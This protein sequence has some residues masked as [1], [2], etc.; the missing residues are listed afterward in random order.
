ME[1]HTSENS[2]NSKDLSRMPLLRSLNISRISGVRPSQ[3]CSKH[4]LFILF[5]IFTAILPF[6]LFLSTESFAENYTDKKLLNVS[7]KGFLCLLCP[8]AGYLADV[9]F[10]RF[11]TIKFSTYIIATMSLA[12][13]LLFPLLVFI[14]QYHLKYYNNMLLYTLYV[15]IIIYGFGYI[16]FVSNYLQFSTDQLRDAPTRESSLFFYALFW[17]I[18]CTKLIGSVINIPLFNDIVIDHGNT[19]FGEPKT[20][21]VGA[22]F[23]SCLA[24]S[25]VVIVILRKYQSWFQDE[26]M[27]K[28]PYKTVYKILKFAWHHK[29]PLRPPTA[30]VYC[31]DRRRSRLDN[32]KERYGGL[33]K[34]EEVEDVKV[35][36][37]IIRVLVTIGPA[38]LMEMIG[39]I[40]VIHHKYDQN[41]ILTIGDKIKFIMLDYGMLSFLIPAGIIPA[42][43]F[44]IKS[45]FERY[46]PNMF[47]RMGLGFL[48]LIA[49]F[50][51]CLLY[52]LLAYDVQDIFGLYY[53][54][55]MYQTNESFV[56]SHSFFRI[57]SAYMFSA[58]H[59]LS[60][61]ATI[62]LYTSVWEF[63][64]CQSPHY[65]K[66]LLFGSLYAIQGFYKSLGVLILY[67]FTFSWES[68]LLS[69]RSTFYIVNLVIG[70]LFFI[71]YSVVTRKYKY[72]QRND[73]CNYY[74]FAE[75]YYSNIQD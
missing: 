54:A 61:I 48:L 24:C 45:C 41:K 50:G 31:E 69:C 18:N 26:R 38:F 34:T 40:L 67:G 30:F 43:I 68:T 35:L 20:Y 59:V 42:Y 72:R 8:I 58:L 75:N 3:L 17:T 2:A 33:Y 32:A 1:S 4:L 21:I 53:Y 14:S 6:I 60:S 7:Y 55:C 70:V 29:T 37:G 51:L 15:T 64:C 73:I 56:I 25:V 63:I 11:K 10:G 23:C 74:Q 62:L 22:A 49:L 65:M 46:V 5:W 71:A 13:A 12:F 47:R 66:G 36:F 9:K 57:P 27:P 16:I 19:S 39:N 52:D 28:N 44:V